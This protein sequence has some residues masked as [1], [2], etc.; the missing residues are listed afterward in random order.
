LIQE[1][2]AGIDELFGLLFVDDRGVELGVSQ[3]SLD[4]GGQRIAPNGP[5]GDTSFKVGVDGVVAFRPP[6]ECTSVAA[7]PA[8]L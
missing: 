4:L 7:K 1:R 3:Q 6:K 2:L 5:G 8:V